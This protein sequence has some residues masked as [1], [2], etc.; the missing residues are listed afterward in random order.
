MKEDM[1]YD[2]IV[3][4]RDKAFTRLISLG[5]S[6]CRESMGII[7]KTAHDITISVHVTSANIPRTVFEI[8]VEKYL[9]RNDIE[10][11]LAIDEDYLSYDDTKD[12]DYN[13]DRLYNKIERMVH[14]ITLAHIDEG[15]FICKLIERFKVNYDNVKKF[16]DTYTIYGYNGRDI[17]IFIDSYYC[18]GTKVLINVSE[19]GEH[20][21]MFGRTYLTRIINH[22]NKMDTDQAVYETETFVSDAI[23]FFETIVGATL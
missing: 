9:R 22:A 23:A 19:K 16:K 12:N 10:R 20:D 15:K 14:A 11:L 21:D 5:Y 18:D 4:A 13:A 6:P 1:V 17:E 7:E 8:R 3:Q 2:N